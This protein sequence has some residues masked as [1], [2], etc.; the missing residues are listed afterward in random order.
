MKRTCLARHHSS[1]R[2]RCSRT[3]MA[4][5]ATAI[6]AR[7][8]SPAHVPSTRRWRRILFRRFRS[9]VR[10]PS[11]RLREILGGDPSDAALD[12]ALNE[13][14][15][16]L[17]ITR[18]DYNQEEGAFVG[19]PVPL[20]AG[21]GPRRHELQHRRG[22]DRAG[23]EVPRLRRRRRADGDRRVLLQLHRTL[24]C[25]RGH[26]C[27]AR[28]ARIPVRHHRRTRHDPDH[29]AESSSRSCARRDRPSYEPN[30]THRCPPA[31]RRSARSENSERP[32]RQ[33]EECTRAQR[34]LVIAIDGPAGAGK[35]TVAAHLARKFGYV[36][37]ESGAM[38]RALALRLSRRTLTA[39]RKPR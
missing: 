27:I 30:L 35:S 7:C 25:P 5:W 28:G 29:A 16:K 6:R 17:R 13:L 23:F 26:Q 34:K 32:G 21:T 19:R 11:H 2:P 4:W 37:L 10:S 12:R 36:N 31:S 15:S 1:Y 24:A 22:A 9:M 38:Y 14:W 8:R 3:S 39:R 33:V 18:V 20:V